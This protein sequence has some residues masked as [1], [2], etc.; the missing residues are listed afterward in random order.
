M[1]AIIPQCPVTYVLFSN[2]GECGNPDVSVAAAPN[3][4]SVNIALAKKAKIVTGSEMPSFFAGKLKALGGD[5]K[6]SQLV[7][8]G[9]SRKVGGVAITTV[10]AV[11]LQ[12][13][14]RRIHRGATG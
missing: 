14:E 9:A 7:R 10:P 11:H 5:P 8:F 13:R 4:N 2:A 1:D 12:W 6:A 3:T